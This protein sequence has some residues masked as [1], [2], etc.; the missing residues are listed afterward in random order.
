MI[1]NHSTAP[2]S[3][4]IVS[5]VNFNCSCFVHNNRFFFSSASL[6]SCCFG[7]MRPPCPV[8]FWSP[9]HFVLLG[10]QKKKKKKGQHLSLVSSTRDWLVGWLVWPLRWLSL[11]KSTWEYSPVKIPLWNGEAYHQQKWTK[12]QCS[13]GTQCW[14]WSGCDVFSV[15]CVR[16]ADAYLKYACGLVSDYLPLELGASLKDYLG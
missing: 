5:G 10:A 11:R 14:K 4:T 1:R 3:G 6:V 7:I 15:V 16:I 9:G 8:T 12:T 13:R 2:F